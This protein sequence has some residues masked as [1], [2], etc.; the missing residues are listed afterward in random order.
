MDV[1]ANL[2]GIM[3]I[4]II[5]VGA[6]TKKAMVNAGPVVAAIP[7]A[8][9]ADAE[10]D[11]SGLAAELSALE[12]DLNHN[13][14]KLKREQ[15]EVTYRRGERDQMLAML[16][17]A[18][19]GMA[20]KRNSLDA[21]QRERFDLATQAVAARAELEELE[22]ARAAALQAAVPVGVI[23]HL[24][25]PM[26]KTVFGKELHF[27]LS[28]GRISYVPMDELVEKLK[29]D[30]PQKAR[31]LRDVPW[32]TEAIGPIEN[33]WLKFT[34]KRV[35]SRVQTGGG[36][37]VQQRVELEKFVLIPETELAGEPVDAALQPGSDFR[38]RIDGIHPGRTTITVWTYPDSFHRYRDI[39]QALFKQGLLTAARPLP[40][41]IPISGS[42]EGSRS[43]AQ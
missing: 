26:A 20:E 5:I 43:A 1:V 16:M 9:A 40:E 25:T 22:R 18:E 2:V 29:A 37:S 39:K 15:F 17:S 14:A 8:D 7:G 36:V 23:E 13:D 31:K 32:I 10:L 6:A 41:G 28:G 38:S 35:E 21:S 11:L 12:T 3:I 42:P 4:L 24:P 34:L 33:Y 30:A 27:R 19:K